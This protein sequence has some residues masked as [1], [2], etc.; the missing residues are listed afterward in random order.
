MAAVKPIH[1]K[2]DH[3]AA[4]ERLQKIWPKGGKFTSQ[5]RADE[6]EVLTIVIED[7]EKKSAPMQ[8]PTPLEALRFEVDS[9]EMTMAQLGE[10]LGVTRSRA[11][12]VM[13]AKRPLTIGMLQ[14]LNKKL[15]IHPEVLLRP[16]VEFQS[17]R[18]GES[19]VA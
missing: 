10:V 12:E 2:K 5:A 9:R 11:S 8:L 14:T 13:N 1:S 3:K 19:E 16:Q 18:N 15:G 4:L 7:Y 6:F 17:T